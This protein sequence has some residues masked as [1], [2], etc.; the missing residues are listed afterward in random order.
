MILKRRLY[1]ILRDKQYQNWTKFL[2]V[3]SDQFNN[4]P[5]KK[6]GFIK[7][8]QIKSICDTELLLNS[9][10]NFKRNKV[11]SYKTQEENQKSHEENKTLFQVNDFVY[12]NFN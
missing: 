3:V 4:T 5:Q 8:I 9:N 2:K 12:L 10:K 11:I 1:K 7:P 6:L